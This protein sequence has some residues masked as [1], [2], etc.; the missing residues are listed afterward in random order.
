MTAPSPDNELIGQ[1]IQ[2]TSSF[3]VASHDTNVLRRDAISISEEE[4]L[5]QYQSD[6][7]P[8]TTTEVKVAAKPKGTHKRG[9]AKVSSA[10]KIKSSR[11][12]Q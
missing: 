8:I 1:L 12:Q 10:E 9:S 4:A 5:L 2:E 7:A 6:V 3:N 11:L